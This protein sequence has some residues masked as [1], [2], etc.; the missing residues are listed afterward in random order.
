MPLRIL[1][2]AHIRI[3]REL[4]AATVRQECDFIYGGGS[5]L[6]ATAAAAAKSNTP[7]GLDLEDFHS[8]EEVGQIGTVEEIERRL[9]QRSVF[10]TAGSAA[11]AK[12]YRAKY[13]LRVEPINNT[14]SLRLLAPSPQVTREPLKI[15]WFSQTIGRGRGLEEAVRESLLS[16]FSS[17]DLPRN[18]FYGDGSPIEDST[19]SR[20]NARAVLQPRFALQQRLGEISGL[21]RDTHHNGKEHRAL[22]REAKL[23]VGHEYES[24]VEQADDNSQTE[25]ADGALNRFSRA[26]GWN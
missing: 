4:L 9:L 23:R 6:V 19:M 25:P 2:D 18:C 21:C 15:Y 10:L 5:A 20:D 1:G 3:N 7:F 13:K 26:N 17:K 8:A 16:A 22:N 11:I 24:H 12:G 14:F